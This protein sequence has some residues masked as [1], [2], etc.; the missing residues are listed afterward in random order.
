MI[1]LQSGSGLDNIYFVYFCESCGIALVNNDGCLEHPV[2]YCEGWEEKMS[3]CKYKGFRYHRP[4][5]TIELK[6]M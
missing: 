6:R 1:G 3:N 5:Q 2:T 4:I